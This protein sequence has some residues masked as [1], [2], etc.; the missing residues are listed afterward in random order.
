MLV[1]TYPAIVAVL[2]MRF[3]TRLPGR[4]PWSAL[5]AGLVGVVLALGGIDLTTAPPVAGI[6]LV[7]LSSVIYSVWIILSARLSG[8][9]R[10]ASD[11]KPP[12]RP[13]RRATPRRRPR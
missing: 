11:T 12:G 7:M 13:G 1:Y 8:E 5:G 4:R 6:V 10:D 9:R 2:S 3:G